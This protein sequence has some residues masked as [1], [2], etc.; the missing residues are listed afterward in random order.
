[1]K[2]ILATA[3]GIAF[4]SCCGT[5]WA[6]NDLETNA[7]I[8]FNFVNPGARSLGMGG[9]FIGLADDATTAYTNPAGLTQLRQPEVAI[10]GRHTAFST[11]FVNGGTVTTQPFST[12]GLNVDDDESS[13]NNVS[14]LSAVFPHDRWAF[15]FYR[16]ELA[17]YQSHFRSDRSATINGFTL[18]QTSSR[19]DLKIVNWGAAA[20]F[21]ASDKISLGFGVSRYDFDFDT[22]TGRFNPGQPYQLV[23]APQHGDDHG[24]GFNLGARFALGERLSL[25]V[26]YRRAPRFDYSTSVTLLSN[27]G[28]E[29]LPQ[30]QLLN[31]ASGLRFDVPDI[32]GAGISWRPTDAFV[33]NF[34]IDRV[35]Y[36]Q[37]TDGIS[38]FFDPVAT[39]Y[40]KIE[41]GTEYHLGAEYTFST[42]SVPFSLRGGVWHDPRH[43]VFFDGPPRANPNPSA[44]ITFDEAFATL[45]AGGRGSQT[46]YSVGAGWAFSRFQ[47][48]LA[49]DLSDGVDTYSMSGVYRF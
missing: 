35:Q 46:H 41:D 8:P 11:P 20:A 43:S 34:D 27:T 1:M 10:E 21:A 39:S 36:S 16:H 37:L 31:S 33:L 2:R 9:A 7:S 49:A 48:D 47:L 25:G 32:W 24:V 40:L 42:M 26:S 14:Y 44:G 17:R 30:P 19:I 13:S 45:F 15:A 23:S 29:P 22:D 6:I 3:I 18:F 38:T 4:G 5:A 12:A 28:A